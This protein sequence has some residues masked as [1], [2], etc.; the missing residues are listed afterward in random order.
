MGVAG[1]GS[2]GVFSAKL[3]QRDGAKAQELAAEWEGLGYQALW[4][5]EGPAGRDALTFASVLL[6]ATSSI[7]IATG[8]AIIQLRDPVSTANGARTLEE[9]YPGRFIL[10]LGVSHE[11]TADARGYVYPESPLSAMR[12]YLD[13]MAKAS[14]IGPSGSHLVPILLG[15]LGPRMTEL[16]AELTDG[17]HPFLS[18]VDHTG[19]V[20]ELLGDKPA[21]AVEQSV[22]WTEDVERGREIARSHL[23]GFLGRTNYVR[24]FARMG[25]TE[26]SFE[27]GGTN[28][29][30]DAL[31]AIGEAAIHDRIERHLQAGA[32]H[33]CI[34]IVGSPEDEE[35]A[36]RALAI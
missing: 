14:Y 11:T 26:D 25:F 15:A 23:S 9:V 5:P 16:A 31:Y 22:V 30:V 19:M 18:S 28:A 20:R 17:A 8:V 4:I 3:Q 32:D 29:F 34:Q 1:L 35:A 21:L 36:L 2:T 10:G 13:A 6:A 12:S 33:V 24:H 7:K 27:G